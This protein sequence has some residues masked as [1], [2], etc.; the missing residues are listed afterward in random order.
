M[1]SVG[2]LRLLEQLGKRRVQSSQVRPVS[3]FHVI[4]LLPLVSLFDFVPTTSLLGTF[5]LGQGERD[6]SVA[7]EKSLGLCFG[8]FKYFH[9]PFELRQ[10]GIGTERQERTVC[11]FRP[12]G[13]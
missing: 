3:Q 12:E 10:I 11:R 1:L 7:S 13:M 2:F 9:P 8:I 6:R 4:T 5:F